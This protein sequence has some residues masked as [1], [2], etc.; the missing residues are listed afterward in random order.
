MWK[1]ILIRKRAPHFKCGAENDIYMNP[2]GLI[3]G[4]AAKPHVLINKRCAA[5]ES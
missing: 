4:F 3:V 5:K 1:L 2:C